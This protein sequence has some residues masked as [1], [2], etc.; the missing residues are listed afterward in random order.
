VEGAL[1][2]EQ[3]DKLFVEGYPTMQERFAGVVVQAATLNTLGLMRAR[4]E[5]QRHQ[6]EP[7]PG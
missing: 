2:Q 6:A 4:K 7:E 3:E 5:Q 1:S